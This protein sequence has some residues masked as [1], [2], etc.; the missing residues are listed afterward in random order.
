MKDQASFFEKFA[1]TLKGLQQMQKKSHDLFQ[2]QAVDRLHRIRRRQAE[3]R[4]RAILDVL[5]ITNGG[6]EIVF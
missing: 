4:H 2:E 3:L 5:N 1:A 6:S